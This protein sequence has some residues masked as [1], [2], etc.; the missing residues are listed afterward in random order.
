MKTLFLPLFTLGIS[1]QYYAD[2]LCPDFDF[3]LAEHSQRAMNGARLLARVQAGRLHVLFEAVEGDG[4]KMQPMQNITGLELLIGLRLRNPAFEYFTDAPPA[5]LPLYTNTLTVLNAPQACDLVARLFT[6]LAEMTERPLTLNLLRASDDALMWSYEVKVSENM[7]TLDMQH[8]Q[9]GCYRTTQQSSAGNTTRP[10]VLAPELAEAGIWGAVN[11]RTTA[12][13]WETPV[14][15]DFK[16][17]FQ[18]RK[19]KL[20]YY[21]VAPLGWS[22]FDK[23]SVV[24]NSLTFEKIEPDDF[25]VNGILRTQLGLPTDQTVLFRSALPVQRS[26]AASQHI[27][28]KRNG[29]TLV[30]NL[31]Q[32]GADM[33][34]AR[35]VVHLSKP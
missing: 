13:F 32:P 30:K 23:L 1:H 10:L 2:G 35:F 28:L 19:E 25:P 12:E 22:D 9:A 27:Q 29:D 8:W 24:G 18:A 4:G 17:S 15:P 3:M 26:T 16:I 31:P 21:I 14:A 5:S 20:D 34:S 33:P 6:P 7:P 11:I